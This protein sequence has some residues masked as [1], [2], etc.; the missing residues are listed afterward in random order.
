PISGLMLLKLYDGPRAEVLTMLITSWTL[1]LGS[2]LATTPTL[3]RLLIVFDVA[4]LIMNPGMV[5]AEPPPKSPSKCSPCAISSMTPTRPPPFAILRILSEKAQTP[6]STR[7]IFPVS[8]PA[9]NAA[10]PFR[11]KPA[12]FPYWTG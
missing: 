6:R 4:W 3:N 12:P 9:G 5:M 8:D 1:L 11:F 10:H 7:T 2:N